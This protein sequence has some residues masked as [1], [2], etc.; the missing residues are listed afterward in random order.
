M[1]LK[2][3]VSPLEA[4]SKGMSRDCN[5]CLFKLIFMYLIWQWFFSRAEGNEKDPGKAHWLLRRSFPEFRFVVDADIVAQSPCFLPQLLIPSPV[6][7]EPLG[8]ALLWHGLYCNN[9]QALIKH[10][11]EDNRGLQVQRSRWGRKWPAKCTGFASGQQT[12]TVSLHPAGFLICYTWWHLF[13]LFG[14]WFHWGLYGSLF[15]RK[16]EET[17]EREKVGRKVN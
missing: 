4:L 17:G 11:E 2:I 14:F 15:R 6:P 10:S 3:I 9:S 16:W 5:Y 1:G 7:E 8:R 12:G 13:V